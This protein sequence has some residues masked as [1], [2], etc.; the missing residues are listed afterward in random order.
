MGSFKTFIAGSQAT[1]TTAAALNGG[2]SQACQELIVQNVD[3]AIVLH[4][5][6]ANSQPMNLAAGASIT[7]KVRDVRDVWVKSASGTPT[8]AWIVQE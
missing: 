8:V 4:F 2:N 3:A 7:L 1:S 6:D 5:G